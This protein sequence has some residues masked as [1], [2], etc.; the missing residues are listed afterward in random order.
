M[1]EKPKF[2]PKQER[3]KDVEKTKLAEL[4]AENLHI[5]ENIEAL[6]KLLK[7]PLS[8]FSNIFRPKQ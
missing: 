8:M 4:V 1:N 6:T 7:T 2:V 3:G 5:E